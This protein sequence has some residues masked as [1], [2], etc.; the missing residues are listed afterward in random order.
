MVIRLNINGNYINYIEY[1]KGK[2]I[3]LLHGW[4]QNIE[5]MEPI[6]KK[7]K[8]RI[9]IV[10]LPGHGK[11][12]EP[13]TPLTIEDYADSI[14]TLLNKLKVEKPIIIGHSFGGRIGLFYAS[15]YEVEKLVCLAS[16]YKKQI[17]KQTLK[18]KILKTAKKIPLLN[19]LENFAKKHIGSTDY[20]NASEMMR[21]ILVLSVNFD[22]TEEVKKIKCPTLLIW[23]TNDA[24]V[25]IN[26]AYELEKLIKDS[27]VVVYEGCTHYAYLE[28]LNQTIKVL[29][30]FI[31]E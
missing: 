28:R 5:M 24:Q 1:G 23:G 27:G 4:G 25:S 15:K 8:G 20:K 10:D 21:K 11:S 31:G 17:A 19:N 22:M 14:H 7:I 29:E 16:P 12:S 26:D 9:I 3:V 6:G 18:T 13:K 30:S 2:P